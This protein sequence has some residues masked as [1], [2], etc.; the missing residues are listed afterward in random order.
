[1]SRPARTCRCADGGDWF[2]FTAHSGCHV[3]HVY[4]QFRHQW[5][6]HLLFR[7]SSLVVFFEPW[8]C[9]DNVANET[10]VSMESGFWGYPPQVETGAWNGNGK[11]LGERWV[12]PIYRYKY[13]LLGLKCLKMKGHE[14]TLSSFHDVHRIPSLFGS[15]RLNT[16]A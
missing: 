4:T 15:T 7:P 8:I 2:F 13:V 16:P 5:S 14:G 12:R 3:T 1:M 9:E 6:G 10:V 11:E